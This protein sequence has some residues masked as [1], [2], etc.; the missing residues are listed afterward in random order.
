[1]IELSENMRQKDDQTFA[2]LLM[3]VRT[4]NCT[5]EDITILKSR[6]ISKSDPAYP[7]EALHVFTTNKEVD[8]HNDEHLK[9]VPTQVGQSRNR[10]N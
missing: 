4:A 5:Q 1:M 2:Q 3:R 10:L 9:K 8:E 6:V 7:T